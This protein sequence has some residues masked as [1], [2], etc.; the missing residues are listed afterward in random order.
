MAA[1]LAERYLFPD[2][3]CIVEFV[4]RDYIPSPDRPYDCVLD[5]GRIHDTGRLIFDHKP[6]AFEHRDEQCVSSLM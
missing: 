3:P 1:S 6:P 2:G 5:V 4:P